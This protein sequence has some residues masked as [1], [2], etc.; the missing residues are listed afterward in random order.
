MACVEKPNS[1]VDFHTGLDHIDA[2]P[3]GNGTRVERGFILL[4]EVAKNGC[5]LAEVEPVA[6]VGHSR[7]LTCTESTGDRHAVAQMPFRRR[8]LPY[9]FTATNASDF[10]SPVSWI[11]FSS[12]QPI[13][14]AM[15][16][17]LSELLLPG[18]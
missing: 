12:A 2:R 4:R 10:C 1:L 9:G 5:R 17:Q 8:V 6:L 14:D 18:L 13:D 11:T 15:M 3:L 7:D 16:A